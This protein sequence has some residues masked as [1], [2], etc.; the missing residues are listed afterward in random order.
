MSPSRVSSAP[1]KAFTVSEPSWKCHGGPL[2][3]YST[4]CENDQSIS[5]PYFELGGPC[6]DNMLVQVEQCL[7][8]DWD[9]L[10]GDLYQTFQL[11]MEDCVY[12]CQSVKDCTHVTYVEIE[13]T[14]FL[15]SR[16]S[17]E[18]ELEGAVSLRLS[19]MQDILGNATAT[20]ENTFTMPERPVDAGTPSGKI[21]QNLDCGDCAEPSSAIT[22]GGAT[23]LL[24][25]VFIL[26]R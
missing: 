21:Q 18:G 5:C 13:S 26:G 22:N 25:L 9:F 11:A 12:E 14:C 24:L 19:C 10:G 6:Q 23:G 15:K 20:T 3:Y 7:L 4:C 8:R 2:L 16:G 17:V 1:G